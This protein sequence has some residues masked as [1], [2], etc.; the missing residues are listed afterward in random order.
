MKRYILWFSTSL[1]AVSTFACGDDSSNTDGGDDSVAES[2]VTDTAV[3]YTVNTD[4]SESQTAFQGYE[5][6]YIMT[7]ED[8]PV[9]VCRVRYELYAVQEPAIA[10]V[11]CVWDVVVERRN[12][13][14]IIDLDGACANS[15]LA[16]DA[17]SIA[18]EEGE[19]VAYGFVN[20]FVGHEYVLMRFNDDLG[21]WEAVTNASWDEETGDLMYDRRDGFCRYGGSGAPFESSGICGLSGEAVV[22]D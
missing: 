20:E 6:F 18:A 15:D 13:S 21:A 12:P 17:A 10:C 16:L 11:E 9:D 22:K 5:E 3:A 4:A 14:V 19:R 8:D 2:S 1:A 7:N